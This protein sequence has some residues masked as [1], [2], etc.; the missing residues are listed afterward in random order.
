MRS[1]GDR[2][3]QEGYYTSVAIPAKT[4]DEISW[5]KGHDYGGIGSAGDFIFIM[6]YDW[7]EVSSPPGPTAPTREVWRSSK[8]LFYFKKTN[9]IK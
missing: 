8:G 1:L 7:H 5:L 2:L 3:K 6:A 9:T 4:S